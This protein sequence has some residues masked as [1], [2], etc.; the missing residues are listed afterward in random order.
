MNHF[1]CHDYSEELIGKR[2]IITVIGEREES[3]IGRGIERI[4][5]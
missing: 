4:R 1:L 2:E 3:C 5:R